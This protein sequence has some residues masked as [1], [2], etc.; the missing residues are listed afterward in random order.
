MVGSSKIL[1]VSYGTFSCTL[2]GFDD[3]FSTMKAIA[4]YFRD[5]A[6]D[7]RYFGAEPPTPDAEMLARI[8]EREVAQRVEAHAKPEGIVLTAGSPLAAMGTAE[9]VADT[10]QGHPDVTEPSEEAAEDF[11][12]EGLADDRAEDAVEPAMPPAVEAPDVPAPT[13]YAPTQSEDAT[14]EVAEADD[15]T[16]EG[17][18]P[19]A[20]EDA[21]DPLPEADS[22]A[23]K[24]QRIR[25]VVG[26][27]TPAQVVAEEASSL[28]AE[29]VQDELSDDDNIM[30]DAAVADEFAEAFAATEEAEDVAEENT[31]AELET[32]A[33]AEDEAADPED[34]LEEELVAELDEDMGDGVAEELLSELEDD[35]ADVE[36]ADPIE[37]EEPAPVRAR[38]IRMSRSEVAPS[39]AVETAE[40]TD[41]DLAEELD[42]LAEASELDDVVATA[43]ADEIADAD[44]LTDQVF[45]DLG[46]ATDDPTLEEVAELASLDGAAVE[47]VVTEEASSLSDDAEADLQ[48]ELAA[49]METDAEADISFVA[50]EPVAADTSLDD[51]AEAALPEAEVAFDDQPDDQDEIEEAAQAGQEEVA[52]DTSEARTPSRPRR[53]RMPGSIDE[54][55]AAMTRIISETEAK[56]LSPDASR[57]RESIAQLKAAV[58]ATEADRETTEDGAGE[59]HPD[60]QFRDDLRQVV[61]PT[62]PIRPSRPSRPIERTTSAP[63]KLVASQR[64]DVEDRPIEPSEPVVPRRVSS[65]PFEPLAEAGEGF[66]AFAESM[67]AEQLDDLL[68]AAAAYTAHVEGAEDFSRPQLMAKVKEHA[69]D[70]YSREDGLR[71]F[72]TL[73]RQGRITKVRKGRFQV[74][75]DTRFH[76][77]RRAS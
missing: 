53:V 63:L 11:V 28:F 73:L 34:D 46:M 18:D 77:D 1:T 8:A 74:T 13:M 27:S 55:D 9:A 6:A 67:G 37:A 70:S 52:E 32:A 2:E 71:A 43:A 49:L 64:V 16:D 40:P 25:A 10:A 48:A 57:R 5:L 15:I 50:E 39:A 76:P 47:D 29:P 19:V 35:A 58:A 17:I 24:L 14:P 68:E 75:N 42:E 3:S 60:E 61:R 31:V 22:V 62:R 30:G 7:D 54:D 72:G 4:E 33:D 20:A 36:S 45:E 65:T 66:A 12:S 51:D 69:G 26:R 21:A 38:V 59:D 41:N 56:M 44:A 23:A